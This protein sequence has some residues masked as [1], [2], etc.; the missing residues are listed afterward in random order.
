MSTSQGDSDGSGAMFDRIA[1]RYDLL[2][3]VLSMGLDRRWRQCLVR[4]LGPMRAGDALLDVATGPADVALALGTAFPH[5]GVLG[6]D[7]SQG[8]LALGR[9]KL[10]AAG[11][12]ERVA[13][14]QGDAQALS[15]ADDRFAAATVAFGIR[16]VP[17]RLAGLRELARVVRPGGRVAV[18]EFSEPGR[19]LLGRLAG[20]HVHFLVP[21]IGAL[22]SG[23]REYR[24]LQESIAAFPPPRAFAGLM[25]EAGLRRIEITRLTMGTVQLYVGR[26]V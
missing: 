1:G 10:A 15:L 4:S 6:I 19:D 16:N 21:R 18:L 7:P 9:Q 25:R 11:L 5:C 13:L 17:D 20:L 12:Q 14:R 26:K 8:M 23:E 22:L 3:R 24:Y 2:N